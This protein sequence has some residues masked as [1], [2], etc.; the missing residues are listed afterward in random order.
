MREER[1]L[2]IKVIFEVRAPSKLELERKVCSQLMRKY[3]ILAPQTSNYED[4]SMEFFCKM[5]KLDEF[6]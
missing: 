3:P 6:S 5:A 2:G 4:F 1:F